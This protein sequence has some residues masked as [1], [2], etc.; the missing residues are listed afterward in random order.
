MFEFF[1]KFYGKFRRKK[2]FTSDGLEKKIKECLEN[3]SEEEAINICKEEINKKENKPSKARYLSSIIGF[4][5]KIKKY[6][7]IIPFADMGMEDYYSLGLYNYFYNLKT[8]AESK[9]RR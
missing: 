6:E 8:T 7:L 9:I 3:S 2:E 5:F 1:G 4:C